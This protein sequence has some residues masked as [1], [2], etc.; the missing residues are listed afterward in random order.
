VKGGKDD[1]ADY[2][3]NTQQ[4]TK[5]GNTYTFR[6]KASH[7]NYE[8]GNYVTHIY[9]VDR[10][11]NQAQLILNE[12]ALTNP[13]PETIV[14]NSSSSYSIKDSLLMNVSSETS[15]TSLLS[16]FKNQGLKVRDANGVNMTGTAVVGTGMTVSLTTSSGSVVSLTVVVEGDVD[17]NGVV[18]STD[19]MRIKSNFIGYFSMGRAQAKAADVDGSGRVDSTDYMQLKSVFLGEYHL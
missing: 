6:V 1:L 5:S 13:E 12:V 19:Y 17:G 14:L 8:T 16:Q 10:G 2:F 18:D 4:G 9:A 3:M 11:G 7:H 15:V